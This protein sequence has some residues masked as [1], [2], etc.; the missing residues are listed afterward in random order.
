MY[1]LSAQSEL[2]FY[3]AKKAFGKL[4][5]TLH[6]SEIIFTYNATYAFNLLVQSL[7][8]SQKIKQ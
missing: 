4:I 5:G 8:L 6:V 1:D 2:L 7:I 3:D